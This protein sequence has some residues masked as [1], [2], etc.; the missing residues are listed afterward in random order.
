[1]SREEISAAAAAAASSIGFGGDMAAA[2][3]ARDAKAGQ[4]IR[5][6]LRVPSDE[7]RERWAALFRDRAALEVRILPGFLFC[8]FFGRKRVKMVQERLPGMPG[9]YPIWKA[10]VE[11]LMVRIWHVRKSGIANYDGDHVSTRSE[12][13]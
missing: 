5:V 11:I 9:E 12:N 6:E 4:E 2:V 1:M 8:F 10:F 13:D 7:A 3:S